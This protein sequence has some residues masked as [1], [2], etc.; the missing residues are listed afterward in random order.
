[1]YNTENSTKLAGKR[2]ITSELASG[3]KF[4]KIQH[5]A[6]AARTAH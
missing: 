5:S 1:M 2:V 3:G 6:P 4:I